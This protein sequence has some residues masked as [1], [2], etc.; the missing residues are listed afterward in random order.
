M[1]SSSDVSVCRL[2]RVVGFSRQAYYQGTEVRRRREVDEEVIVKLV[3]EQRKQHPRM[4]GR[5][6]CHLLKPLLK[7]RGIHMG[8]DRFFA[9]LKGRGLLVERRRR[10]V[11]TTNSRHS[12]AV[13]PNRIRHIEAS[14]VNQVWVSDLTYLR[15]QE[16]F[17]YLSLVTDSF[18][19]KIVGFC[20][21]DTLE[22]E[23][24][25]K[26]LKRALASLTPG[27]C[28]I[29]HSDRGTQYSCTEYVELLLRHGCLISMTEMNHCYE[30]AQAE[31]VNGILKDEYALGETFRTK[32]QARAAAR[33]AVH[34]YNAFRPHTCLALR[35][36]DEVH[37][38]AA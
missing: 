14:M 11:K 38:R 13:W 8:R 16:G 21:N 17:L 3:T 36:P 27:E 4:G 33:Q 37:A 1:K 20:V 31:R 29:H 7:E 22:S 19:R 10:G 28:P 12:F 35:T 32:E 18:S 24:C 5:K 25:R 15:T 30:N 6:L 26:A 34:L 9:V 23:G 2:C